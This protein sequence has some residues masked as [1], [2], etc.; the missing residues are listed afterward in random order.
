M[1]TVCHAKKHFLI[2]L[3]VTL[4]NSRPCPDLVNR[5][6]TCTMINRGKDPSYY[7]RLT[8]KSEK[9]GRENSL[10]LHL[11]QNG[12]PNIL[13]FINNQSVTYDHDKSIIISPETKTS[14]VINR[15]FESKLKHPYSNCKSGYTFELGLDDHFNRSLYPYFQ[16]ECFYLFQ[17]QKFFEAINKSEEYFQNFHYYFTNYNKWHYSTRANLFYPDIIEIFRNNI[18]NWVRTKL[19]GHLPD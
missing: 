15:V 7:E 16:S 1:V 19:R 14:L 9:P 8:I 18:K 3:C 5:D 11:Y 2:P 6:N 4:Y 17:F 10:Y 12:T 13:L